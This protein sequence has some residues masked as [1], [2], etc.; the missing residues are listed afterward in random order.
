MEQAV[1]V[2]PDDFLSRVARH[3]AHRIV[4]E[5]DRSVGGHAKN[6]SRNRIQNDLLCGIKS[7]RHD[8][9]SER[10]PKALIGNQRASVEFKLAGVT[11]WRSFLA[12]Y[13]VRAH[14]FEPRHEARSL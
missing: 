10:L 7:V 13:N 3:P 14:A 1:S 11:A 8:A 12:I 4:A 9:S 6:C 5:C 2:L